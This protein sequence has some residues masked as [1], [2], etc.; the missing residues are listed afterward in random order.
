MKSLDLGEL[1]EVGVDVLPGASSRSI[2]EALGEAVGLHAVEQSEV[3]HLR[4]AP[5]LGGDRLGSRLRDS[6]RRCRVDIEVAVERLDQPG[7]PERW[8]RIRNSI[9]E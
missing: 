3:D 9:C 6:G 5:L 7:S 8:A 4:P 1:G 2:S